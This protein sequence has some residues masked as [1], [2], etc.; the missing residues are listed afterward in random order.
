[1]K[2]NDGST[3]KE[4]LCNP[5]YKKYF[6]QREKIRD[7]YSEKLLSAKKYPTQEKEWEK[8]KKQMMDLMLKPNGY[9]QK[10]I[11]DMDELQKQREQDYIDRRKTKTRKKKEHEDSHE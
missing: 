10:F 3:S 7:R 4:Y 5:N 9:Y 2:I 8:Y 6:Q 1:M 11:W